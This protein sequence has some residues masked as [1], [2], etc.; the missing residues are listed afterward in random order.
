MQ[1]VLLTLV[2]ASAT[3]IGLI[4]VGMF[5]WLETGL[6]KLIW[7]IDD[8][9]RSL[10]PMVRLLFVLFGFVLVVALGLAVL[11]S[12]L[13]FLLYAAGILVLVVFSLAFTSASRRFFAL[14]GGKWKALGYLTP[15][16]MWIIAIASVPWL[17]SRS[18]YP[19]ASEYIYGLT[20][21]LLLGLMNL[22]GL[23]MQAFEMR[24]YNRQR[25]QEHAQIAE[26]TGKGIE[27]DAV[28]S[29]ERR[30]AIRD[31]VEREIQGAE[32]DDPNDQKTAG[33]TVMRGRVQVSETGRVL[34]H[35]YVSPEVFSYFDKAFDML[36]RLS[37][38]LVRR[39]FDVVGEA[40]YVDVRC[41]HDTGLDSVTEL[42]MILAF[43]RRKAE[44]LVEGPTPKEVFRAADHRLVS[45]V[46][47]LV[48][49]E[50][51][52]P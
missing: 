39:V 51:E 26:Q 1:P 34:V 2:Q 41:W 27:P 20:L 7:V 6:D 31:V 43:S 18:W 14:Y 23:L 46:L 19:T 5:Y 15:H 8:L 30:A 37:A 52:C 24:R 21:A 38:R 49:D 36:A 12:A 35:L 48:P 44:V 17:V 16:W 3:L 10:A 50:S 33:V 28:L 40:H 4:A 13:H 29:I 11:P 25:H 22:V 32:E 42:L 9:E 47:L 45:P